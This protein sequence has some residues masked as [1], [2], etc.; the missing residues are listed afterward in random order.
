[1]K[2]EPTRFESRLGVESKRKN[3]LKDDSKVLFQA[4]R[5]MEFPSSEMEKIVGGVGLWRPTEEQF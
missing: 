5:I 2:V 3:I 1:M 4:G